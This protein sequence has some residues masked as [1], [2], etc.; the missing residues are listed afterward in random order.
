MLSP[1]VRYV[2]SCLLSA[3]AKRV[4]LSSHK[5]ISKVFNSMVYTIAMVVDV[6]KARLGV[7]WKA[8]V[9]RGVCLVALRRDG[10]TRDNSCKR[11]ESNQL[12]A[13]SV[14]WGEEGWSEKAFGKRPGWKRGKFV[15]DTFQENENANCPHLNMAHRTPAARAITQSIHQL[16]RL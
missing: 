7:A 14:P 15:I 6:D 13:G 5:N 2:A 4:S 10:C 9:Q 3:P 12:I 8:P 16:A 11:S 1:K